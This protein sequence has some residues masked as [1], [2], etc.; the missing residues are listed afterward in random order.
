MASLPVRLHRHA[1]RFAPRHNPGRHAAGAN[2]RRSRAP[3]YP[4]G[5]AFAAFSPSALAYSSAL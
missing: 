4:C 3:G 1:Y 2:S 5:A